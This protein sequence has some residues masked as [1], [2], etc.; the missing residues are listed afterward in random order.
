MRDLLNIINESAAMD[1]QYLLATYNLETSTWRVT[2]Y[3]SREMAH[4]AYKQWSSTFTGDAY[5][6]P[7][8]MKMHADAEARKKARGLEEATSLDLETS[9]E[10]PD[11]ALIRDYADLGVSTGYI[12]GVHQGPI[13]DDR[14]FRVFTQVKPSSPKPYQPTGS[15]SIPVF[16]VPRSHPGVW[17]DKVAFDT[18]AVRAKLDDLRAKVAS[19]EMFVSKS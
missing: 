9:P 12:G 7:V 1:G 17:M 8:E 6:A 4:V 3:P 14:S 19:G 13:R 16:D 5:I 15:V 2:F 18:P 10:H 11:A